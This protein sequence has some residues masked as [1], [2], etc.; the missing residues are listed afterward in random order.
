MHRLRS[1]DSMP[2]NLRRGFVL[3]MAS[4]VFFGACDRHAS[5]ETVVLRV[6]NWGSP[7]VESGFLRLEREL[8]R[9]FERQHPGVRVEVEMIPGEGQYA[10]KLIMMHLAD[11]MPDVIHLDAASAAVFIDNGVLRDLM[12]IIRA[13]P[14]FDLERYF[15]NVVD[16]ARRGD[17]LYAV[18]LDFTP[19]VLYYNRRLFAGAGLEEPPIDWTWNA[20]LAAARRLTVWPAG[21][22]RPTRYGLHFTNWMPAW[23]LWLWTGGG[24]VL[25]PDG[26]RATGYLDSPQTIA[27]VQFLVDL[28]RKDRVAPNLDE[29]AIAG[30]DLFRS[31]QAA[32]DLKGH[33]MLLDYRADGLDV[34]I[35]LPPRKIDHPVTVMYEAGLSIPVRAR[36]PELAWQYIRFMTSTQVQVRRLASGLAI[37]ANR[38]A[39]E[40]LAAGN[41][42]EQRFLKIVPHARPPWGASVERY[43]YIEKLGT[44]MMEDILQGGVPVEQALR[45]TAKLMDAVLR[46]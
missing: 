7:A 31:Q 17:R 13:D 19:M 8:R 22:P 46:S 5:P 23:I 10:P 37:S 38:E 1:A 20:F 45:Q 16:I 28:I 29:V 44:E 40:Q 9:E 35:T 39:A 25:S 11:S 27:A 18:P 6:A 12:P 21:A 30:V 33:W 32:M 15:P 2:A 14:Q 26:T 42:L 3:L 41:P 43:P 36:H 24:D 34:G 4:L